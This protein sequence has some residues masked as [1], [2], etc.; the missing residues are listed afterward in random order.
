M[1]WRLLTAV[2]VLALLAVVS[3]AVY[4]AG[5]EVVRG[6]CNVERKSEKITEVR[7]TT[8]ASDVYYVVLDAKG[9]NLGKEGAGKTVTMMG[10]VQVKGAKNWITLAAYE[11]D[12]E[13]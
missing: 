7:V 10:V 5:K 8:R 13:D 3:P 1:A 6:V 9:L 2:L 12:K 11:V 4:A